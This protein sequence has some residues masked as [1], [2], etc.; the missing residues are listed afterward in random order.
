MG[1]R[2]GYHPSLRDRCMCNS[3]GWR[4]QPETAR[5]TRVIMDGGPLIIRWDE[6][7]DKVY[8]TGEAVKVFEGEI[9]R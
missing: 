8:M 6:A 5:T 1:A 2:F 9:E 7:S 4:R 3:R